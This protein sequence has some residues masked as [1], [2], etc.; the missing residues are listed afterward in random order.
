MPTT[1][2]TIIVVACDQCDQVVQTFVRGDGPG[3][4]VEA[5]VF[6]ALEQAIASLTALGVDWEYFPDTD[7]WVC[8]RCRAVEACHAAGGHDWGSWKDS[9]LRDGTRWR[10]CSRSFDFGRCPGYESRGIETARLREGVL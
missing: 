1:E 5:A 7:R 9:F 2:K 4:L 6:G 10:D 8:G 3:G